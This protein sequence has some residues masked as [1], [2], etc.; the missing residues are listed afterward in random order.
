M[1]IRKTKDKAYYINTTPTGEAETYTL[2]GTGFTQANE[3]PSAQTTSKRYI[4]MSSAS[5]SVTGYEW[6][7]SFEADQIIDDVAVEYI[8][9]IGEEL[10]TGA[11]CET[12]IV[13]VDLDKA[14]PT[15]ENAFRARKFNVAIAVSDFE[16]ND[17]ELTMSGDFLGQGDPIIGTFATTTKTF[18]A[19]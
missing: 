16:D 19:K 6:S 13:I 15:P 17:G 8:R 18:T 1:A 2:M 5:Q 3:S 9:A 11:D 7:I 10:K 14:E 12:D 4:N